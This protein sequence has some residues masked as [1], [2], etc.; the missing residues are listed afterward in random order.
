MGSGKSSI[1]RQLAHELG[2][3]FI[4]A[5]RVLEERTGVSITVIFDVEGEAG[6]RRRESELLEELTARPGI[7]LA[8]G[9][10]AVIAPANR[11]L[12]RERGF[13]VY[14]RASVHELRNRTRH[15][16]S[17][18]LLNVD[19]PRAKLEALL[20]EREPWYL[21]VADLVVET[22]R[23]GVTRVTAMIREALGSEVP[24]RVPS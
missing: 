23:P 18:P 9:G 13:T 2:K 22:G 19:D 7:I 17:R 1:G 5:D 12:L 3:E 15:D 14:L 21:E 16:R 24:G 8:T 6:F 4:D 20:A 10:G 11:A